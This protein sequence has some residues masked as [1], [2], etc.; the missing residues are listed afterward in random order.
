MPKPQE[1]IGQK[2]DHG[3]RHGAF[4]KSHMKRLVT[5]AETRLNELL[6]DPKQLIN[7]YVRNR[8]QNNPEEK[9]GS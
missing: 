8:G 9:K 1:K 7:T 6:K 3:L 4:A 2:E 5:E